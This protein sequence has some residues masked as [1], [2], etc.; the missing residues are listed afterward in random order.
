[1][2]NAQTG[3]DR[4]N[5]SH[6]TSDNYRAHNN[7]KELISSNILE[8]KTVQLSFCLRR[9]LPFLQQAAYKFKPKQVYKQIATVA[10]HCLLGSTFQ[11]FYLALRRNEKFWLLRTWVSIAPMNKLVSLAWLLW[12]LRS[13]RRFTLHNTLPYIMFY[14]VIQVGLNLFSVPVS[15]VLFYL[16]FEMWWHSVLI[17]KWGNDRQCSKY[18]TI[19]KYLE[20]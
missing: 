3:P 17:D 6:G 14:N 12:A 4:R 1:M 5:F 11:D 10:S 13:F 8:W 2:I 19:E 9:F 18:S 16:A 7:P 15:A 20:F